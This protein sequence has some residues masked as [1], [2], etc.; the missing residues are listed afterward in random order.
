MFSKSDNSSF[1]LGQIELNISSCTAKTIKL[2]TVVQIV[3]QEH[4]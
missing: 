2:S 4:L 1:N 3:K